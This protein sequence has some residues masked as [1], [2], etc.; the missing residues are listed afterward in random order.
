[1][2]TARIRSAGMCNVL[3]VRHGQSVWNRR[4]RWQGSL[5][6]PLTAAGRDQALTVAKDL[7]ELVPFDSVRSSDLGRAVTTARIITERLGL[8]P[9]ATDRR[10]R[11][12]DAGEWQG[13]LVVE[14]ERDWPGWLAAHRRPPSFEPAAHVVD[15]ATEAIHEFGPGR[16]LVITHSG[17]I[18]M[19]VGAYT[20][21]DRRIPNAAGVWIGL[22][23]TD[24]GID[25]DIG[26][27]FP[28]ASDRPL[29]H[30]ALEE[31]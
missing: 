6:S 23:D 17:V 13:R 28:S 24:T 26:P 14:I 2:V 30:D 16:H 19:L 10:W 11:E 31:R 5:D 21:I 15:R 1:M 25:I 4:R 9:P 18:R 22:T 12:A 29:N 7:S 27:S 20:G 3:L 8:E